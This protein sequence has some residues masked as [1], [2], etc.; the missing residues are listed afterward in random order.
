MDAGTPT[1]TPRAPSPEPKLI[2][3]G[4][5]QLNSWMAQHRVSFGFTTYQAGKFFLIGLQ[6]DGKLSTFER[7]FNRCMGLCAS[8]D[9]QTLWMTSLYQLWRFENY[10][11]AGQAT[12]DGYDRFYVPVTGF[13]TGDIDLHDMHLTADGTPIFCVT[14][15]NCLG[16]V[17]ATHSFKPIWKPPFIST[18]A[19]EDRCHLNG[20]AFDPVAKQPAYVTMVSRSDVSD[21]W[22]D[23]RHGGGMV[24]DVRTNEVVC[25]G[26]SMPH[27]PRVHP[28]YPDRVWVLNAGTGYFGYVDLASS[29]R[30]FVE[31]AFCPGF[32]RGLS[33]I[34]RHAVVG[35]SAAR[36]NRTFQGL[37]LDDNLAAKDAE[38]RCALHVINLD[39]GA[40]EHWLRI[41]GVV[42]ELYD[43]I[44]LP[45]VI[46][47]KMLGF[48]T[49]EIR[50]TLR[51]DADALR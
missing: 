23:R 10:L 41:E 48:K 46:R 27:S 14:L 1:T 33:F 30:S 2:L 47:P 43:V 31:V 28:D 32:T 45:N 12:S 8:P 44:A 6:P 40:T 19:P 25:E 36:E 50:R 3:T 20:L 13:T 26:L 37:P 9:T 34:G 35:L 4:S 38:A 49:D 22:R 7:T 39:T 5:R 17:S 21:G 15:F 29:D 11:P 51:V 16:T 24:M 42:R 18:L